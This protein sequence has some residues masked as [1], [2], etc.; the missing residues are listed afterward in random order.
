MQY[1]EILSDIRSEA[2]NQK[3]GK[4]SSVE[5]Q[6]YVKY[7]EPT[8]RDKVLN[9][10]EEEGIITR[11]TKCDS[12]LARTIKRIVD[13]RLLKDLLDNGSFTIKVGR[14][15]NEI[16]LEK[17]TLDPDNNESKKLFLLS[18][19][20][21]NGKFEIYNLTINNGNES[22]RRNQ[23][24]TKKLMESKEAKKILN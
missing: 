12:I 6:K 23:V 14:D 16:L 21:V 9:G 7:L 4:L 5:I 18:D 10:C 22:H 15:F 13:E 19:H 1:K 24:A 2:K 8:L 20:K 17:I 3:S 11:S